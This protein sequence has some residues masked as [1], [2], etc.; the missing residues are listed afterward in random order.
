MKNSPVGSGRRAPADPEP[1][2][3]GEP[4]RFEIGDRA[5]LFAE[6]HQ[7]D[8]RWWLGEWARVEN[9]KIAYEATKGMKQ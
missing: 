1:T 4:L 6:K 5:F 2:P 7:R 3:A 8:E 9:R